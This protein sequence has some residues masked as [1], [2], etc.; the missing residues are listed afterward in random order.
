M[1][2]MQ[3]AESPEQLKYTTFVSCYAHEHIATL[4]EEHVSE[5]AIMDVTTDQ[6]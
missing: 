3:I 4:T 1:R 6:T 2:T 5:T